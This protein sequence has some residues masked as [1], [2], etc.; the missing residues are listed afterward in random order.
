MH[1]CKHIEGKI[2][3]KIGHFFRE[4]NERQDE[5]WKDCIFSRRMGKYLGLQYRR[6]FLP[7]DGR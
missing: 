4:K 7:N 5:N 1:S 6:K 2:K 3:V